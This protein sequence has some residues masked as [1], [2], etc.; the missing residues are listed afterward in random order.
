MN[1]VVTVVVR[2]SYS[3][4]FYSGLAREAIASWKDKDIWGDAYHE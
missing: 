1:G 3:D 2:T 4:K